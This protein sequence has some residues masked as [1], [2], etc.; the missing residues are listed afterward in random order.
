MSPWRRSTPRAVAVVVA[1]AAACALGPAIAGVLG[2]DGTS[3]DTRLGATPPSLAHWF[4]TDVLGRDLLVRV[5]VGGRIALAVGAAGTAI[6]LALGIAC[7]AAAGYAGGA[8]DAVLMRLVDAWYALPT[9]VLA[10]VVM[11]VFDSRSMALL[12][13]LI[14]VTAWPA[15]ARVVRGQVAVLRGRGFVAAARALGAS[16]VRVVGT[17]VLPNAAGAIAAYASVA[18]PQVMLVE[19]LLSFLGVGVRAPLASWGTLVTEASTQIVVYPWLLWFPAAAMATTILAL[20][21]LADALTDTRAPQRTTSAARRTRR[22]ARP[23][24]RCPDRP[25]APRTPRCTPS[26]RRRSARS[27]R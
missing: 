17:H 25:R 15:C 5:L 24:R 1:I 20:Y 12:V 26:R 18:L 23:S 9:A 27:W 10:I 11:A 22:G 16:P 4:G 21:A 8:V 7:G 3:I 2:V 14:G 6:A 13:A 19:A